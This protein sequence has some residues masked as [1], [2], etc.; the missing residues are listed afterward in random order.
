MFKFYFNLFLGFKFKFYFWLL[1]RVKICLNFKLDLS[2]LPT[3]K[4]CLNFTLEFGSKKGPKSYEANSS[5]IYELCIINYFLKAQVSKFIPTK[6]VTF[7]IY[8]D[9][10]FCWVGK[11]GL[12]RSPSMKKNWV[13]DHSWIFDWKW[14]IKARGSNK[15]LY[16]TLDSVDAFNVNETTRLHLLRTLWTRPTQHYI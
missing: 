15:I 10:S 9:H 3:V 16:P 12:N 14:F 5:L 11:I 4:L 8:L 13:P 1:P 2:P 7:N 6:N